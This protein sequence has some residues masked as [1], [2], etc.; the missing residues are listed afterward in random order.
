MYVIV[1]YDINLSEREG[2]RVLS[3]VFKICKRYLHH[4]QNS[5]FEGELL[6]SQIVSLKSELN[7]Y[8]RKDLDSIIMFKSRSKKWLEK[9][10]IGKVETDKTSNFL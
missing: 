1:V 6:E 5:T 2:T 10:F 9:E 7:T 4:I 8:I 3:K